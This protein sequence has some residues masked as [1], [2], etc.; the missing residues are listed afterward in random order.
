[1]VDWSTI[2]AAIIL[3]V[4]PTCAGIAAIITAV[5]GQRAAQSSSTRV[6]DAVGRVHA[7]VNSRMSEL[8][9]AAKSV[10]HAEGVEQGRSS[11]G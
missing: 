6:E 4:P 2:V 3:T 9:D 1:M 8:L 11:R 10:S 7:T 5:R